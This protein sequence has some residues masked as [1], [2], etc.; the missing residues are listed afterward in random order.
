MVDAIR[1]GQ[2][3]ING[4]TVKVNGTA[5]R[6]EDGTRLTKQAIA[7]RKGKRRKG[8]AEARKSRKGNRG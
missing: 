3:K 6:G 5:R 4:G 2:V 8:N 7:D 1:T